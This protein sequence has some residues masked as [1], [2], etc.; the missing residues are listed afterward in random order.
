MKLWLVSIRR[1]LQRAY[2]DAVDVDRFAVLAADGEAA[3]DLVQENERDLLAAPAHYAE[4][5]KHPRERF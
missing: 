3:I 4:A 2:Y 1:P 5:P